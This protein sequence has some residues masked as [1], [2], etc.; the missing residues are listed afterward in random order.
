MRLGEH[1]LLSRAAAL[2]LLAGLVAGVAVGPITAYLGLLHGQAA[3]LRRDSQRLQRYRHLTDAHIPAPAAGERTLLFPNIPESQAVALL[4]EALKGAAA[5]ARVEIQGFQVLRSESAA[6]STRVGVRLR[7]SGDIAGLE[8]L[9][10]TIERARPVLYP[11][12]LEVRAASARP[13]AA[14]SALEFEFD[15]SGFTTG[16]AA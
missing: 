7:A 2:V 3:A 9:L 12:N 1:A 8:R 4:Q 16:P 14:P 5:A 15:V 11:D 13:G 6:G 10:Y